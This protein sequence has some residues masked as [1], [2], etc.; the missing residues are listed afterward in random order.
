MKK[1]KR[2]THTIALLLTISVLYTVAQN[3]RGAMSDDILSR[4]VEGIDL[5][6]TTLIN[7]T[8]RTLRRADLPGGI[9]IVESCS[10][11]INYSF[12]PSGLTLRDVLDSIV[13]R[14]SRY[15]WQIEEGVVNII[16][17]TRE[18]EL[19][20]TRLARFSVERVTVNE[21]VSRLFAIPEVRSRMIEL[22]L[23]QRS[24]QVGFGNLDRPGETPVSTTPLYTVN[25]ANVTVREALNAIAR[26][27][28]SAV[29]AYTEHRCGTNAFSI[30][31]LVQ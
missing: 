22:N 18:P 24:R 21:A 4:R 10:R 7:A 3:S 19:L 16:P 12:A 17:V 6:N 15:R 13:S 30:D 25:Q 27:H 14:D 23:N 1:F 28:G 20:N 2:L 26:A 5:E 31:F 11:D 8:T 29:W 9:A